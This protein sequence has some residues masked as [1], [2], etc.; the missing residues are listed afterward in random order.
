[1]VD[2]TVTALTPANS[3]LNYTLTITEEKLE[4]TVDKYGTAIPATQPGLIQY[5]HKAA[6][7]TTPQTIF[8]IC[9]RPG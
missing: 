2:G 7:D 6:N 3:W 8:M 1:M 5:F 9:T 4:E